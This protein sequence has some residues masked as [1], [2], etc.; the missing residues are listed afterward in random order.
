MCGLQST[1][2]E[3]VTVTFELTLSDLIRYIV[4]LAR[5]T[6]SA[7]HPIR[8]PVKGGHDLQLANP[9]VTTNGNAFLR[10]M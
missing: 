8:H 5:R 9:A 3:Q 7:F 6:Y 10:H 1:N 2:P 4:I